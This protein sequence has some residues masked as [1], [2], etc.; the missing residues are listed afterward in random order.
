MNEE[1]SL[2]DKIDT[3]DGYFECHKGLGL[4]S[5]LRFIFV[6]RII[7]G[8]KRALI[9]LAEYKESGGGKRKLVAKAIAYNYRSI[10]S[11]EEVNYHLPTTKVHKMLKREA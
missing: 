6:R 2:N 1:P 11:M 7:V 10:T 8:L 3:L 5:K 9:F 4:K